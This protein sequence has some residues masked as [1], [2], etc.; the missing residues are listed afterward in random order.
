MSTDVKEGLIGIPSAKPESRFPLVV[1]TRSNAG[2]KRMLP[3]G[4]WAG[5]F[6]NEPTL[7]DFG[8]EYCRLIPCGKSG[9]AKSASDREYLG[10]ETANW[11][12]G[13]SAGAIQQEE[14]AS[15]RQQQTAWTGV[16][17]RFIPKK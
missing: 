3:S 15:R 13:K 11:D 1:A 2:W 4:N 10:Q 9:F 8:G 5:P 7:K 12:I 16:T 17:E 6:P 14:N